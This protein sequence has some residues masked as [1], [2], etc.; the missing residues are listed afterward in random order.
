MKTIPPLP[1]VPPIEAA[2]ELRNL[3]QYLLNNLVPDTSTWA[4]QV[5]QRLDRMKSYYTMYKADVGKTEILLGR[6]EE[7]IAARK[8]VAGRAAL[9]ELRMSLNHERTHAAYISNYTDSALSQL[10]DPENK[11]SAYPVP[12]DTMQRIHQLAQCFPTTEDI[13]FGKEANIIRAIVAMLR[14]NGVE[15]VEKVTEKKGA[16]SAAV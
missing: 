9:N 4:T 12:K 10:P 16:M 13:P 1:T 3:T 2:K 7:A 8:A 14:A 11:P 5:R 15:G 6:L